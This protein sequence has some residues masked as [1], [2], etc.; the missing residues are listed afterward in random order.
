MT[1]ED[2][3]EAERESRVLAEHGG[4]TILRDL[5]HDF[6]EYV[7]EDEYGEVLNVAHDSELRDLRDAITAVLDED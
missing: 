5:D 2:P 1:E 6:I 7:I 3:I 4:V